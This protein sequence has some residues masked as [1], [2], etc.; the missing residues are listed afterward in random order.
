[1]YETLFQNIIKLLATI[2]QNKTKMPGKKW[3]VSWFIY[4]KNQVV[5]T[6]YK[7]SEYNFWWNV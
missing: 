7:L 4:K 1:M 3:E 2:Y 6:I 5:L